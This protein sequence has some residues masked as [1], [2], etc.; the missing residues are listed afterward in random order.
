MSAS[1]LND[2]RVTSA[3][4]TIPAWG[5]WHAEVQLD[6][7]HTI[8][9]RATLKIADLTLS[10]AVLS[11]GPALGRSS[12]CIVAGAGGWGLPLP[13]KS[14]IN[15][16]G[17]KISTV[18]G[19]AAREAGESVAP[20]VSSLRV[21][22][23]FERVKDEPASRVLQ[24]V[25]PQ[26]WYVDEAGITRLGARAAG[27]L[28]GKVTRI[29]PVDKARGKVVLAAESIATILPGVVVD[30]LTAVDVLHEVSADGGLRSTVW[31][32]QE[33]S[34]LDSL[35]LLGHQLDPD[36][37]FR[38]VSEYRVD[39]LSGERLNLQPVRVSTG[40]PELKNVSIRPGVPG[41]SA[42][43]ALGAR[44]L[45]AFIDG[46]RTRPFVCAFEDAEGDGFQPSSLTL[47]AGGMAGG[48]H[49]MTV[50]A[51]AVAMHNII[52]GMGA[53]ALPS[54]WLVSGVIVGIIN[55]ALAA[56]AV[57][58]SPGLAAQIAAAATIGGTMSSTPTVGNTSA[59]YAAAIAALDT[60]I[61][62]VSGL[63]PSL[64]SKAVKAG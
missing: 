54:A 41:C 20:I 33:P 62:N 2:I 51:F 5:L 15:D 14:Y 26:A 63:F 64:G 4:V 25:A 38:G 40:L 53:A 8:T 44:V 31:G 59:P 7:E 30:G 57:P 46:D 50:E 58:A 32:S 27:A 13:K 42:V 52:F 37:Q 1:T 22:S 56:S 18:V 47:Q 28:V 6:G 10:G 23:S 16:A 3:R 61:E 45:V 55:A 19:D 35:A 60:K 24:A 39:T 43:T 11:G 17:V 12:Y 21:G 34:P 48:E 9:G 49:V 29:N 36:R